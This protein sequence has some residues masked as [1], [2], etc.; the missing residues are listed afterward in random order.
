M[1]DQNKINPAVTTSNK[2]AAIAM[3]IHTGDMDLSGIM[4]HFGHFSDKVI[5]F[6]PQL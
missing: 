5:T 1:A 3:P 2:I 4:P 6:S